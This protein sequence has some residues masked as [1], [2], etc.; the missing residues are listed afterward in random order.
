MLADGC[1]CTS[2][3]K[4]LSKRIFQGWALRCKQLGA[5]FCDVHIVFKADPELTTDVDSRL[6]AESHV[7]LQKGGIAPHQIRPLVPIHSHAMAHTMSKELVVRPIARAGND[8]SCRCIH[9]LT[10][11][12]RTRCL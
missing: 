7:R 12:T 3:G 2:G 5:G 11:A 6:V 1:G 10:L 9:G 4:S 8:F